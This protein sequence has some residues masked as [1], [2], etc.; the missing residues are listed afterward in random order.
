MTDIG[1]TQVRN[2]DFR[3]FMQ[4]INKPANAMLPSS[5]STIQAKVIL[6]YKE[7]QKRVRHLLSSSMTSIHVTCDG[8]TSSNRLGFLGVIAHFI[9][10]RGALQTMLLALEEAIGSHSGENMTDIILKVAGAY[11]FRDKLGYFVMNNANN[12]DTMMEVIAKDLYDKDGIYYDAVDH[13]LRCIG[14]IINLSVQAFLFGDHP[15]IDGEIT[16]TGPNDAKLQA[17]RR[18]E[19]LGKLHNVI[20]YI[21]HSPQRIQRFKVLSNDLM[22][23]RDHK[24]K[25]NSWWM[26]LERAL[27]TIKGALQSFIYNEKELVN[28][29]LTA[30]D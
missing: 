22:P 21:M 17:Y 6:L 13:R 8:W 15:D 23:V 11:G 7:G 24:I 26:M 16:T 27:G 1:F 3:A 5:D 10:E 19:P 18:F 28:D 2:P 4:Y 9:N 12:N 14:H 20:V 29:L 25:W 30:H